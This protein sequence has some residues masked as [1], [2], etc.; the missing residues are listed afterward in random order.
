MIDSAVDIDGRFV[1]AMRSDG[2]I[3]ATPT[4]STAYALSAQG[5]IVDPQVPALLL[6]PVAPHALTNRPIAV[7]DARDDHRHAAARQRRLG[8]LRRAGAFP[9]AGRRPRHDPA[10]ARTRCGSCIPRATTTSRC[11]ARSCTGARRPSGCARSCSRAPRHAR[12]SLSI[13]NFVV[14]EALDLELDARLLGADRRDRRRQVD[15]A[16]RAGRCCSATASSCGSCGPAPS[17]PSSPRCSTS[18][19]AP[20]SRRGSPNRGSPRDDDRRCCCG[21]RWTRRERAAPGSTAARR[22]SRS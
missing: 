15:P 16:R 4:G 1:Y 11:C 17:A 7:G 18:T 19:D 9:A 2:L 3:V 22:R 14:V 20:A 8:A 5:P 12:G 10:R 6:V 13:R 21:A